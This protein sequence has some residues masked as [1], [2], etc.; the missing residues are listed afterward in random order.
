VVGALPGGAIADCYRD[1]LKAGPFAG[2]A[3][4]HLEFA[5]GATKPSFRAEASVSKIS[6]C[7]E[8][9]TKGIVVQGGAG[10]AGTADVDLTFSLQ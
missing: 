6:S 4:L 1:A 10:A 5:G 9:V 8:G 7:V 2:K 3:T